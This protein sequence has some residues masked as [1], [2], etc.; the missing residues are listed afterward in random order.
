MHWIL[1]IA[2]SYLRFAVSMVVVFLM[3]PY[4]IGQ[5][6][7]DTF[8]LWSLI[9]AVIGIFGLMDFGFATAAVKTVAEATG[10]GDEAGR[11]RALASL[12]MLY[13]FIG[14]LSLVLVM[15]LAVPA[16]GWFDL[17]EGQHGLFLPVIWILGLAVSLN[18]PASLFK[19]AL[20]GAG[21]MHIV[22]AVELVMV[23]INAGLVYLLLEAGH[24]ITGLAISTALTMVGTSLALIP[25]AYRLLPGFSLH[26][27][28][29]SLRNIRPLLSFSVY[30]FMA[31]VAVL[32][33]L[34]L[35]PVVIK[36]FLPLSAV[37]LY[38]VAARVSEYTF[39]LNKQFSNALMPLVSQLHGRGDRDAIRRIMTDGTRFLLA[40]A[41]PGIGL[42]YYYAPE[43]IQL[44]LGA[45]FAGS[46][47]LL[48]ILLLALIPVT[49]Q[50]NAANILGMTGQHRFLAIAMLISAALNLLLSMA[51]IAA[52]GL[53]GAALGTLAAVLLVEAAFILPR[54]CRH[55]GVSATAFLGTVVWPSLPALLPMLGV[56]AALD[57]W[58]ATDSLGLLCFK[59]AVCGLVY[60][61]G[62]FFT[63][64]SRTERTLLLGKLLRGAPAARLETE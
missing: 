54:A 6:G 19:A 41:V 47:D 13:T 22:N 46:A 18:F 62:F 26:W 51:L 2:T 16:A 15:T 64:L 30:A 23:L 21:R 40:L 60:L 53:P 39:L 50:L 42:L 45:E 59:V 52:F 27:R 28:L 44:W 33:T 29:M 37:A 32:V 10:A 61:T 25:L 43:F 49:L 56:A 4:I 31:N 12:L 63:G 9:F 36:L 14:L 3:T 11:N 57:Q 7:M 1:N 55:S 24:G 34:R 17:T 35:D 5:L 48:R 20:S 8:G 58:L 38:A